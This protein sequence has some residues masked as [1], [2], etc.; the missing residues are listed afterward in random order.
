MATA[1]DGCYTFKKITYSRGFLNDSTDATYILTMDGSHRISEVYKQLEQYQPT[2]TV[3]IVFNKG[4]KKCKKSLPVQNSIYDITHASI[5]IF[6]HANN[7]NYNNILLLEDDFKF[8]EK[9]LKNNIIIY[10]NDFLIKRKDI[11]FV[12]QLGCTPVLMIPYD[13]SSYIA[14]Y[15]YNTHACIYSRI[16]RNT[17]IDQPTETIT[18]WDLDVS[19]IANTNLSKFTYY[20]PLCVQT[21][22]QTDNRA[23]WGS[24]PVVK[25]IS[26]T[27]I[28]TFKLDTDPAPG[29]NTIY[30]FAKILSFLVLLFICFIIYYTYRILNTYVFN[31]SQRGTRTR[32]GNRRR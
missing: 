6:K 10:L 3:Y 24:D 27:V 20:E 26:D 29:T 16:F 1:H 8:S 31:G 5:E 25:F 9:I 12:Y 2:T 30:M 11:S 32:S 14:Y 15:T 17:M 4:Y 28:S 18:D 22:E 19:R 7:N 23:T 21:A 13:L